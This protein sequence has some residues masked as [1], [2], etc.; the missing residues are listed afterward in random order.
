MV[1]GPPAGMAG[2]IA[3]HLPSASTVVPTACPDTVTTTLPIHTKRDIRP[4]SEAHCKVQRIDRM[5][6]VILWGKPNP[7]T[8][9]RLGARCNTI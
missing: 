8:V 5:I 6:M 2:K 3:N 4:M 1:Y 7:Q 9:A